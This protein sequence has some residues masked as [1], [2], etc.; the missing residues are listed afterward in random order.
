MKGDEFGLSV[1]M[2]VLDESECLINH[3]DEGTMNQKET[4]MLYFFTLII[5]YTPNMVLM[6]GDR[7]QRSLRFASWFGKMLYVND[8]SK[9][10]N[11]EMHVI[12]D[13]AKCE[14]EMCK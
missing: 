9:N 10:T 6:D 2:I 3:F 8:N 1:D 12:H 4:D 7:N 14:N 11:N 5:K 13:P